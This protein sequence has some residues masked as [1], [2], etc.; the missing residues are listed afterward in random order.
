[1]P[2]SAPQVVLHV[3]LPKTGTTYLQG[4]LADNRDR[5]RAAGL[6]YPFLR[7]GAMFRGAVE[8]RGSHAKFG[9]AEG[10]VVGTWAALCARARDFPGTTVLSH[11]VLAGATTEQIGVALA[12]L[13]GLDVHVVV[14]AR[15][16]GR[17]ATAHWQ[18]EIKLGA[19]WSFE[20]LERTQLRADSGPDAGPDAGGARPHFW[21]AQDFAD[22]LRRWSTGVPPHRAHLVVAPAPGAPPQ[23]LWRRFADALGTDPGILD[24]A[25]AP[26]ANTSLATAEIA[27]LRA[28][29]AELGGRLD[30]ATYNRVVKRG[31]AEGRLAARPGPRPRAPHHLAGLFHEATTRWLAQVTAAGHPV[32]GDPADLAPVLA[33]PG[34]PSPDDAVPSDDPEVVTRALLA[35]AVEDAP[36]RRRRWSPKGRDRSRGRG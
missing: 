5:L 13:A 27:L 22:C 15:D 6:L 25:A 20:E 17:Q 7:P 30:P 12:P 14:T 8:I 16:L 31:Y 21:H 10:D 35:E 29:N 19:T 28:V 24:A 34:D 33:G 36:T 3:G 11:E 26:P 23:E 2:E 9:L 18:E 4:L 32:H 1:M